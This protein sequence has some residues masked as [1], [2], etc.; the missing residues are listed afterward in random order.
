M[1]W[2]MALL[3]VRDVIQ[4]GRLHGRHLGFCYKFKFIRKTEIAI[5]FFWESCKI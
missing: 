4:N 3:G 2:V 5:I 1:L